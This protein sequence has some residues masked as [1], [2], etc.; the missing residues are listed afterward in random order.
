MP[1]WSIASTKAAALPSRIGTSE[2]SISIDD[3]VDAEA[4]Q[5][6]HQ[7]LDGGD[8]ARRRIAEHGAEIGRADLRDKRPDLA[9]RHRRSTHWKTMPVSASA[10]LKWTVTGWPLWTPM[11]DSVTRD[12]RVV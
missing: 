6:G 8:M 12:L 9:R 1:A 2:P 10:G 7:M 11:P 4:E 3:I 5:R